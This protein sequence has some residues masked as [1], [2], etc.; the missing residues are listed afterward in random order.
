MPAAD[1]LDH[2][3][4]LLDQL[5]ART[6]GPRQLATCSSS[7]GWPRRGVY[8]FFEPGETRR[9]GQPR[10]VRVGTHALKSGSTTTLWKRLSQHRGNVG[11][12][13]PGGGNHRGSIFRLHVGA[14][15][16]AADPSLASEPSQGSW[17]SKSSAARAV[18][19]VER[20]HERRVSAC[21]GA[22]PVLWLAIDDE[23]GPDSLRGR[24]EAGSIALLSNLSN[25]AADPPSPTWLGRHSTRAAVRESGLWN[26]NHVSDPLD[27]GLLQ[28][29]EDLVS[30]I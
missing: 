16:L 7:T 24:V 26:V 10:V 28:V 15:L 14:C 2:F 12:S 21:I 23:P 5:S 3:Y 13:N 25:P 18:R 8:F 22:M 20:N 9:N 17:G 6:G 30:A 19:D 29:M 4:D 27:P 1:D 11:G